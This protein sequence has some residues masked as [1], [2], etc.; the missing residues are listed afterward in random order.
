MKD[1]LR[2]LQEQPESTKKMIVWSL[3]ILLGVVLL[4]LWIL[5]LRERVHA[6]QTQNIQEQLPFGDIELRE[7]FKDISNELRSLEMIN[8]QQ[9][10]R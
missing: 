7:Q 4:S 8:N 2:R 3:T 5:G 1:L 9:I 10:E 6:I